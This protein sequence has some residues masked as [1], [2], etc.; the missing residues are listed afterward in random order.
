MR[1]SGDADLT[2]MQYTVTVYNAVNGQRAEVATDSTG[3]ELAWSNDKAVCANSCQAAVISPGSYID[4]GESTLKTTNGAVIVWTPQ[5]G[6]YFV[7]VKVTSQVLGDPGNDEISYR[8]TVKDYHDI[9]VDVT[10]LD[11]NGAEVVGAVEGTDPVDFK[12]TVDLVSSI[13][14]MNIRTTNVSI[15]VSSDS[16]DALLVQPI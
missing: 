9:Q 13:P 1:N 14:N 3:A 8:V 16:G 10:W 7:E 12:V 11:A 2:N 4:G 6:D 5:S 15:Q